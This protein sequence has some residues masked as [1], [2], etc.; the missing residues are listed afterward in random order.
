MDEKGFLIGSTGRSKRVFSKRMWEKK[1][2]TAAIQDTNREWISLLACVCADGS[3]L[4]PSLVYPSASGLIQSSWVEEIEP[5]KHSVHVTSSPSGWTNNDMGLAWLEQVFDRYTKE[6]ARRSYR[7][8]ILDGHRSHVTMDF[9]D[10]CDQNRIL[11]MIHP[12]HSTPTLQPLDAVMFKALSTAYNQTSCQSSSREA[13]GYL[14]S[15]RATSSPCSGR[16]G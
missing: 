12:L 9:I 1:E 13:R 5:E 8:L 7:L 15:R 6:K 10:Y 14:Q 4:P 3:H 2:F 11:L 16:P